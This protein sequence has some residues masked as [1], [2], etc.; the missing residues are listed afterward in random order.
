ME[1]L[2]DQVRLYGNNFDA[3]GRVIDPDPTK[4]NTAAFW[5][6]RHT[7]INNKPHIL[8]RNTYPDPKHG[9]L[10]RVHL[11]AQTVPQSDILFYHENIP[12][13]NLLKFIP[14][15]NAFYTGWEPKHGAFSDK[16]A[17]ITSPL[18]SGPGV[19]GSKE[20]VCQ[21]VFV[22]ASFAVPDD[23]LIIRAPQGQQDISLGRT[24]GILPY[25]SAAHKLCRDY[26]DYGEWVLWD[27]II[28][29][30]EKRGEVAPEFWDVGKSPFVLHGT[31]LKRGP[32]LAQD[33]PIPVQ[34]SVVL[35]LQLF[36]KNVLKRSDLALIK[37]EDVVHALTKLGYPSRN[38]AIA[39]GVKFADDLK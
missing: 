28:N 12:E 37:D 23:A 27:E 18:F 9:G 21:Q 1:V 24:G 4:E 5:M 35:A 16:L 36:N 15:V 13:V 20:I 29:G 38:S 10:S 22:F 3:E 17:R 8:L 32:D 7:Q 19:P 33:A 31:N 26:R 6:I 30:L 2:P 11:P 39:H 14:R 34:I 25:G